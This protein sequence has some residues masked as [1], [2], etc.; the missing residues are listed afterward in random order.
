MIEHKE[1][2][3]ETESLECSRA[4]L[5]ISKS[6]KRNRKNRLA[7]HVGITPCR[8]HLACMIRRLEKCE[9]ATSRTVVRWAL[10]DGGSQYLFHRG[11]EFHSP[12]QLEKVLGSNFFHLPTWPFGPQRQESPDC[13]RAEKHF[14]TAANE[15]KIFNVG[16]CEHPTASRRA[17]RARQQSQAFVVPD[18]FNAHARTSGQFPDAKTHSSHP[19]LAPA[20][21]GLRSGK[22]N[23]K[24]H[25]YINQCSEGPSLTRGRRQEP[26]NETGQPTPV[27]K[28]PSDRAHTRPGC[29]ASFQ[30]ARLASWVIASRSYGARTRRRLSHSIT[31]HS[32]KRIRGHSSSI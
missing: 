1:P 29:I 22:P 23:Y 27:M 16:R 15:N 25:R 2:L 26:I 20:P 6:V 14:A 30:D 8:C 9:N 7:N 18:R 19:Q 32:A 31:C 10:L 13:G 5:Q 12:P 3:S 4:N 17:V 11:Q 24:W 21:I 28:S